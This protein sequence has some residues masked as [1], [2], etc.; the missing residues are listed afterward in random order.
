MNSTQ[1]VCPFAAHV[2]RNE[3]LVFS[4]FVH[5]FIGKKK[6]SD[7]RYLKASLDGSG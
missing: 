6:S 1:F 3:S 7:I 2:L 4:D 5:D